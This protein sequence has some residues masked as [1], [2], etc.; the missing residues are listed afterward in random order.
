MKSV[1][2]Y[3]VCIKNWL[4]PV[5]KVRPGRSRFSIFYGSISKLP[6]NVLMLEALRFSAFLFEKTG[7]SVAFRLRVVVRAASPAF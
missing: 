6:L 7:A 1:L 4:P 2:T 5:K 3:P